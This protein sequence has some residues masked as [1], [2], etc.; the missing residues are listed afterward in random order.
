MS[1]VVFF[2]REKLR[3]LVALLGNV[4]PMGW[5]GPQGAA[6][7]NS[8]SPRSLWWGGT[9]SWGFPPTCRNVTRR[10]AGASGM[11]SPR[12]LRGKTCFPPSRFPACFRA[13]CLLC[14][15]CS[16]FPALFF[17]LDSDGLPSMSLSR[18]RQ[19]EATAG[20]GSRGPGHPHEEEPDQR[21]ATGGPWGARGSRRMGLALENGLFG[22]LADESG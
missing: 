2:P 11:R 16:F 5:L 20:P 12:G 7:S 13:R 4:P 3:G 14:L 21:E 6:L 1:H 22:C 8:C 15:K 17:Q 9:A 18:G 10:S 19:R